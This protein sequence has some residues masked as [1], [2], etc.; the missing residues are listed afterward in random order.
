[1]KITSRTTASPTL[2]QWSAQ[3]ALRLT[4]TAPAPYRVALDPANFWCVEG[5]E[6]PSGPL[7]DGEWTI[8]SRAGETRLT[9]SDGRA[10]AEFGGTRGSW[11]DC[12]RQIW[13]SLGL[14]PGRHESSA[15]W[16]LDWGLADAAMSALA[17]WGLAARRPDFAKV[18]GTPMF[19][20]IAR[21]HD[22]GAPEAGFSREQAVSLL[23]MV[24]TAD[25]EEV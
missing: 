7:G 1:M 5:I 11:R 16:P 24:E 25:G 22:P 19:R 10:T 3:A 2:A 8:S 14:R 21:H 23:S 4:A 15:A 17:K 12:H 6:G 13:K 18:N 20:V 9:I